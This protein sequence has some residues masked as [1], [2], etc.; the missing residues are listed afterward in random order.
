M[1]ATYNCTNAM[2]SFD[3]SSEEHKLLLLSHLFSF[4]RFMLYLKS[5]FLI[6]TQ[7]RNFLNNVI[8]C[9]MLRL[10]I[11]M[12][13]QCNIS[14]LFFNVFC[15]STSPPPPNH[16]CTPHQPYH[17]KNWNQDNCSYTETAALGALVS[18]D[19][20]CSFVTITCL[21]ICFLTTKEVKCVVFHVN[22]CRCTESNFWEI[23]HV[24]PRR[25]LCK[26]VEHFNLVNGHR[27]RERIKIIRALTL[28]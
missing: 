24:D 28:K 14:K 12:L 21:V 13:R 5:A 15:A 20:I 8:K 22:C 23:R 25:I 9:A 7:C 10:Y 6:A 16:K 19:I 2:V 27:M 4:T 3:K 1:K 11:H 26:W 18:E 17:N